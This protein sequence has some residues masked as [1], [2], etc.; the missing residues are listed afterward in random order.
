MPFFHRRPKPSDF[1]A[2]TGDVVLEED[3]V[4]VTNVRTL[5]AMLSLEDPNATPSE[6]ARPAVIIDI[7]GFHQ[8]DPLRRPRNARYI[9]ELD[10]TRAL[11]DNIQHALTAL[12]NIQRN[13][14]DA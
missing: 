10:G 6:P 8:N 12:D 2:T 4:I 13:Q 3:A 11:V 5:A 14:E 7:R 9:L 1:T